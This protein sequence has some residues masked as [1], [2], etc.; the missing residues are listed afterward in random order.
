MHLGLGVAADDLEAVLRALPSMALRY[1]AQDVAARALAQW[2][3]G[4]AS[5]AQVLHPALAGAPGHGHWQA[6][7]GR[8]GLAA[9]LF[10]VVV[11]ARFSSA[12]VDAFCDAL[13]LFRLGYSW[14]G[15]LSLVM[16]YQ[17]PA[18]RSRATPHLAHGTVVRFAV[19]LEDVRDL[20]AD[21]QQAMDTVFC[22]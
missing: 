5:V 14:G 15:P 6:L 17:L 18:M 21:L 13:T 4:Q 10:S 20:R 19:G 9:G 16:P 3:Q 2:L 12:Q 11:D 22:Q 1:Q 7:C 8:Q